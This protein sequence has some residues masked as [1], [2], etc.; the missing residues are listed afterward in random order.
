M[1]PPR[2]KKT[3]VNVME[4]IV[5][6]DKV[7]YG[8]AIL[9]V[10]WG[11]MRG[12]FSSIFGITTLVLAFLIAR[13]FSP[14]L[15]PSLVPLF[16]EQSLL[17]PLAAACLIFLISFILL[18]LLGQMIIVVLKKV[19]VGGFDL[20]GGAFFGLLRAVLF[21]V[22]FILALSVFGVQRSVAWRE[23]ATVP[24]LGIML[25]ESMVVPFLASHSHWLRFDERQ[26]PVLVD[27]RKMAAQQERASFG[28]SKR[29]KNASEAVEDLHES[30][31]KVSSRNDDLKKV[32]DELA[33]YTAIEREN[34]PTKDDIYRQEP[35]G[36]AQII[37]VLFCAL[38]EKQDCYQ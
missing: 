7:V 1:P 18:G 9:S 17:A 27:G 24:I 3:D 5:W 12:L 19:D 11:A 4:D 37:E 23:S 38:A 13:D 2:S 29:K 30:V 34:S 14:F 15:S 21:S 16:G 20:L 25:K 35:S 36:I 32:M 6:I 22:I 33:D 10:L 31:E 28:K 8:L 26:R